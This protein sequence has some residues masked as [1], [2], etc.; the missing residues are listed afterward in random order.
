[1]ATT[2]AVAPC[3][4]SKCD[5]CRLLLLCLSPALGLLLLLLF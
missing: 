5:A 2:D 3:L 4:V 1:M